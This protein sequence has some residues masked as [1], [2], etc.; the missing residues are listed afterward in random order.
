MKILDVTVVLNEVALE[1]TADSG[2]PLMRVAFNVGNAES[3]TLKTKE[4]K[5][6]ENT[7]YH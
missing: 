5:E 4:G 3:V 2:V 1:S 6:V 7:G